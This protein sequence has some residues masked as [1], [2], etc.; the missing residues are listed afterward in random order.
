[1]VQKA[2]HISTRIYE[3]PSTEE[4]TDTEHNWY[5][6][7]AAFRSGDVIHG[8]EVDWK[9]VKQDKEG[10]SE[11]CTQISNVLPIKD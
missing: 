10:P 8:L 7:N 9:I 6:A 4:L 3:I 2:I 1:M 5:V 11:A